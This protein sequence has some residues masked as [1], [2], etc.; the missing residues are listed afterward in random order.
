MLCFPVLVSDIVTVVFY[1]LGTYIDNT[2]SLTFLTEFRILLAR[3]R[4]TTR[5]FSPPA[6]LTIHLVQPPQ[7]LTGHAPRRF[8]RLA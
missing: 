8:Y 6:Y 7:Y 1:S 3:S 5:S 4:K 2:Q